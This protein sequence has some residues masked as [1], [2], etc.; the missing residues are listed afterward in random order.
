MSVI[1]Y[2]G[3]KVQKV[4]PDHLQTHINMGW[5]V[6]RQAEQQQH[7]EATETAEEKKQIVK[8]KQA[9]TESE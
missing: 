5:S 6:K 7:E 2:Q 1:I 4:D 8:K 3:D 9:K